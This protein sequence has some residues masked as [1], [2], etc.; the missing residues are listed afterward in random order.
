M[1]D[2]NAGAVSAVDPANQAILTQLAALNTQLQ[3]LQQ[4]NTAF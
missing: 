3:Q 1:A 2:P 4:D